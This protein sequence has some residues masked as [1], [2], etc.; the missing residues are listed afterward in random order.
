[1]YKFVDL[2]KCENKRTTRRL[3][4]SIFH[5]FELRNSNMLAS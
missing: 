2:I 1:M 5:A 3:G 4:T